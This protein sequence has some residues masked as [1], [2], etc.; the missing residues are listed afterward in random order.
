MEELSMIKKNAVELD[1]LAPPEDGWIRIE[2]E[3]NKETQ[4]KPARSWA[5]T[6]SA[7]A[8]QQG[9][10]RYALAAALLLAM[11]VSVSVVG[12][13]M[14]AGDSFLSSERSERQTLAKLKR[15][16]THYRKAI[17]ALNKAVVTKKEKFDPE[18]YQAFQ[19]HLDVLDNS[20]QA[21]RQAVLSDPADFETRNYLL[22]VYKEK[23]DLLS[24]MM[25][26]SDDSSQNRDLKIT[27]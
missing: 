6:V 24:N 1:D 16:E 7:W 11:I 4:T 19:K 10:F 21:C 23:S 13:R 27:L 12:L 17:Q 9:G 15:A 14:G 22:A 25:A 8:F 18:I 20:I 26:A 2:R 5:R 3:L